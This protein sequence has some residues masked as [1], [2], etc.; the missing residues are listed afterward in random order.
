MGRCIIVLQGQPSQFAAHVFPQ[1]VHGLLGHADHDHL[2][3][4]A[5]ER[6]E[7]VGAAQKQQDAPDGG[8]IHADTRTLQASHHPFKQDGC[9]L[10][11][12]PRA[13]NAEEVPKDGGGQHHE[14]LPPMGPQIAQEAAQRSLE[15]LG[16]FHGA[17]NAPGAETAPAALAPSRYRPGHEAASSPN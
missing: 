12:D 15:I 17:P 6:A 5:E 8:K 3:H 9:A 7:Q 11:H 4:I 16:F 14:Q 10:A 1:V 2:L 13:E